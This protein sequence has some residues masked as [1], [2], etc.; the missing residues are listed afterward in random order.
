MVGGRAVAVL[1]ADEGTADRE[2]GG[3]GSAE[4]V[5]LLGRHAAA[6]LAHLTAVRSMQLL[7]GGNGH[8]TAGA[9]SPPDDDRSARRYAK[10]LISEIKLYN[11]GAVRVGCQKRDLLQRLKA[12]I[13]RARRLYGERVPATVD[14]RQ[15]YFHEEL[16]HTLAG[17][18]PAALGS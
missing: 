16:I 5:E 8:E 12:E 6:C 11:E 13:D 18:D 2:H 7:H 10:L 9:P 15:S 14:A 1:Y 17:G 4:A 3:S